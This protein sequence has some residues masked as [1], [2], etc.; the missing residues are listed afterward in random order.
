MTEAEQRADRMVA[1]MMPALAAFHRAHSPDAG[2]APYRYN[3]M[4][5]A[6]RS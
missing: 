6:G 2:Y 1:A 3:A 4:N 5:D